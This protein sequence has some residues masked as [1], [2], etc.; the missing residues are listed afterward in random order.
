MDKKPKEVVI[1]S[2][3]RT[4]IG[5]H[6]GYYNYLPAEDLAVLAVNE[7]IIRSGI[8]LMKIKIDQV[9]AG[10]IYID[11]MSQQIY[12]PRNVA[13]RVAEKFGDK[14][15][16]R[17]A[18]GKT[19]LRICGTGFQVLA[20]GFDQLMSDTENAGCVLSFA[21]ENMSQTNLIHQGRRKKESVWDFEEAP[22]RDYLMEGFNHN[23]FK[24]LM[25]KTA[26]L[27]GTQ[28][29]ITR[30]ECDEF[31]YLSHSRAIIAQSKQWNRYANTGSNTYLQGIFTLDA[32]DQ[33]GN[34][35]S[36]WRDEGTKFDISLGELAG[37]RPMLKPDGLVTPGTA[38]QISD[39]AAAALLMERSFADKH[40]I[41]YLAKIKGYQFSTV[42]PEIMGQGPVPAI[43]DLLEKLKMKKEDVDLFEVNEAFAAQ[44]LGVEKE[45]SLP[46]DLTNV[47]GGAIAI[48]H[49]IAATGLRITI[50][51][52]Y[53]LKRQGLKT[54]IASACIGGGQGGAVCVEIV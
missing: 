46:R 26:E 10:M 23:L 42:P 14:E 47:N 3:A 53:E 13:V 49:N 32:V 34:A 51:L 7:A 38:S 6:G 31:A 9:V 33:L 27:Y 1:V 43:R 54:G 48:G 52:I 11:S 21:T 8:D 50:D 22:L 16:L 35:I 24:T 15:N 39:G 17:V 44:Y 40:N 12:L 30:K 18:P 20:D 25:P 5:K 28:T 2:A 45:L 37:L 41:P 36:V 29:G 19:T 4:P